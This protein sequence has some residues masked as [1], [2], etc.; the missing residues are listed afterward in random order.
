MVQRDMS[1]NSLLWLFPQLVSLSDGASW[2]KKVVVHVMLR[3]VLTNSRRLVIII[4]LTY[5][6]EEKFTF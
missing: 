4:E 3:S 2:T 5:L 6:L 1:F